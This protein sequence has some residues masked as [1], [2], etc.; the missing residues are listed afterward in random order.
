MRVSRPAVVFGA[1]LWCGLSAHCSCVILSRASHDFVVAQ[2]DVSVFSTPLSSY[3]LSSTGCPL[4]DRYSPSC[5]RRR[6]SRTLFR[7]SSPIVVGWSWRATI[8][9]AAGKP[10]IV[11][12]RRYYYCVPCAYTSRATLLLIP[13]LRKV[14]ITYTGQLP[15]FGAA[16]DKPPHRGAWI[17]YYY[18]CYYCP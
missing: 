4:C 17:T 14:W 2:S 1:V 5:V 18:H 7:F 13:V 15:S 6:Y 11:L 9:T 3:R 8:R 16:A 12:H 10:H